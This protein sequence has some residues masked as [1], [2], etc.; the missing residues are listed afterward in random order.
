MKINWLKKISNK[1]QHDAFTDLN[2]L[3]NHLY[4]TFRRA[5]THHSHDG[6][7]IVQQLNL[8]GL[9][10]KSHEFTIVNSDLRDPKISILS[11]NSLLLSAYSRTKEVDIAGNETTV[12][13]NTFW[14]S[15]DGNYWQHEGYFATPFHWCWRLTIAEPLIYSIAYER[16]TENLYLYR[17]RDL[18]A[19]TLNPEPILSKAE[20]NL[21]YPNESD[22][23][24]VEYENKTQA[25]AIVRRDADSYSTQIGRSFPPYNTW[26]WQ[27]LPI[28]L[29]SPR[30]I[31]WRKNSL[32]IAARYEHTA[33]T[34]LSIQQQQSMQYY[35]SGNEKL[36][37]TNEELKTGLFTL[38]LNTNTLNLLLSLPSADDN[39]YPG[40]VVSENE[41]WVSYYS[42][43]DKGRT[44]VYIASITCPI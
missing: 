13:R 24:F 15:S 42:T 10:L 2:R 16:K 37:Y 22:L 38:D 33:L 43:P 19:M 3:N 32:L 29:A 30:V 23:C 5:T 39:G 36:E 17:G 34:P 21:G 12:S 6:V 7:I 28:Y 8:H 27:E 18:R 44:Q 20:H 4:L 11:D 25:L 40:V 1:N 26:T 41:C 9:L 35:G 31:L 14:S